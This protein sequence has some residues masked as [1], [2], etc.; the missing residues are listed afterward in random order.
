MLLFFTLET[1]DHY[2]GCYIEGHV[3]K[4]EN[5][6]NKL[7]VIIIFRTDNNLKMCCFFSYHSRVCV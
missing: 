3:G 2:N 5:Y 1:Q 7:L 4:G 6:S